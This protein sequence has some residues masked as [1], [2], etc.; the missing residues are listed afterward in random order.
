MT[1]NEIEHARAVE[2]MGLQIRLEE[3]KAKVAAATA[4]PAP[5][6]DLSD[7]QDV[8]HLDPQ[9]YRETAKAVI[10]H[11]RAAGIQNGSIR[12]E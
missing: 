6:G 2:L 5:I 8:A 7:L 9:K 11:L 4:P 10:A 3:A 12:Q 1:P